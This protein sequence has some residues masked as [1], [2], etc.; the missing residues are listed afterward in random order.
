MFGFLSKPL[1]QS[2]GDSLALELGI[3]AEMYDL[4][5]TS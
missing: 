2:L 4:G 1:D 5:L 3:D